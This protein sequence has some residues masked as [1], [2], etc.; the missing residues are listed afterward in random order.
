MKVAVL[1]SGSSGNAIWVS[2]GSTAV[3]IDAGI[4]GR[5]IARETAQLGLDADSLEAVLVTH[6]HN[7]HV[8]GLGPV[9]RR[10][11]AWAYASAGTHAA[12]DRRLG[13]CPGRVVVEAGTEF[14]IGDLRISPFAVSH[15]CEEPIGYALTDG[16]TRVVVATDLGVVGHPVRERMREADCVVL[17]FNHDERML[18]DGS[19][20]WFLQQRIMGVEGHLSNNAAAR[21][22]ERLADRPLSDIILAHLSRENNTPKIALETASRALE[23]VGRTDVRIH[24]AEQTRPTGPVCLGDDARAGETDTTGVLA[25]CTR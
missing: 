6:E 23:S 18:L 5:R 20:P 19:Y 16:R 11:E 15:D 3:L 17:E 2:A 10:F 7:D 8:S 25:S 21:E 4:S 24:L 1:A 12:I 13:K 22:I 14:E 9:A